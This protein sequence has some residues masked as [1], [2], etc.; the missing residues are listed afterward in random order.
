MFEKVKEKADE[1]SG[2][3]AWRVIMAIVFCA[4]PTHFIA[5]YRYE[6]QTQT[7]N[8]VAAV[9]AGVAEW[10]TEINDDQPVRVF[11]FKTAQEISDELM[12]QKVALKGSVAVRADAHP[13]TEKVGSIPTGPAKFALS[14][15]SFWK[16]ISSFTI[17]LPKSEKLP[18][19]ELLQP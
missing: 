12:R 15:P 7:A 1:F 8:E 4:A 9:R 11:R 6:K 17:T 14:T 16:R 18:D 19:A 10:L 3:M 13:N 5:K 2:S